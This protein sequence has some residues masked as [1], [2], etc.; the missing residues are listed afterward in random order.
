[1]KEQ[2]EKAVHQALFCRDTADQ[3]GEFFRLA[4]PLLVKNE[5]PTNPVNFGLFYN[6]VAGR[7]ARLKEKLDEILKGKKEW[8]QEDA[9]KLFQRFL[10][11]C[12]EDT[13]DDL[14]EDLL[15]VVAQVVGAVVD[16]AGKT[17]V[18]NAKIEK[19]MEKLA[20]SRKITDVLSA[21]SSI[22]SDSRSL[23]TETKQ[24]ETHLSS[25]SDEMV[26]LKEELECV[27]HEV[28]LDALTGILNRRGF[29]QT[30]KKLVADAQDKGAL[31][32]SLILIDLDHFKQIND[33][34]GHLIGD[35]VLKAIGGLLGKH[36]KGADFCARYGGEEYAIL[37]PETRITNAFN[38]AENLRVGISKL[39][40]KRPS[41]GEKMADITA[42]FGVAAYR[43]GEAA[44][45]FVGRVDKALYRAK[46]LGRNRVVLAD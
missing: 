22:L 26:R 5:L 32:F 15:V 14:R 37:L 24:L 36:T 6:Y 41:T 20:S 31:S 25:S 2:S 1:M 13:L 3:A 10:Y 21:V 4:I 16:I 45:D 35:K 28:F 38:L 40:L 43:S 19:H 7:S 42:S 33:S 18:S 23:M 30:L 44:E 8:S 34:H 11:G 27:R 29:D 39:V 46:H 12:D 9:D 17:A